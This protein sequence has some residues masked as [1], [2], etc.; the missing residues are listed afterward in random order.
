MK[1]VILASIF[2]FFSTF[3]SALAEPEY[4]D[5]GYCANLTYK[6]PIMNFTTSFGKLTYDYTKSVEEITRISSQFGNVTQS[7]GLS[8]CPLVYSLH[9][10][11][12][13]EIVGKRICVFTSNIDV[14]YGYQDPTIYINNSYE[15]GSCEFKH[16]LRHEQQHQAI[17][18]IALEYYIPK[19][20]ERLQEEF[21]KV[22]PRQVFSL[23]HA[24]QVKKEMAEEYT[25][26]L[27]KYITQVREVQQSWQKLLDN[28]ENYRKEHL[29]CIKHEDP[30]LHMYLTLDDETEDYELDY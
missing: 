8:V 9:V 25:R 28:D 15:E 24:Q 13:P 20:K 23:Q 30:E 12:V 10:A 19:L 2:C 7:A 27:E 5:D 29:I 21:I 4:Y 14:F 17:N 26:I 18:I 1:K 3:A 6:A 11:L 22:L 16:T